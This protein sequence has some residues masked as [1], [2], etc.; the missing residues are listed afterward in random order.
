MSGRYSTL[1]WLERSALH[2][3]YQHRRAGNLYPDRD[4]DFT[5]SGCTSTF[6]VHR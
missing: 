1:H 2:M 6:E 5:A 4:P 3:M